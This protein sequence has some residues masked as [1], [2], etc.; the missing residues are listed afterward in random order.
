MDIRQIVRGSIEWE[1]LEAIARQLAHRADREVV[2]IE[3]MEADNWLSTPFVVDEEWFV[4]VI[5]PQNA[6]VH[7]VFTGARNLGAFS[8]GTEGF[9]ERFDGPLEMGQYEL[10]ATERMREIGLNAPEPVEVFEYDG[11]G[12]LVLEYLPEFRTLDELDREAFEGCASELLDSLATMHAHGLA[13]GD[14]RAENVLVADGELYFIDATSVSEGGRTDA[15]AYDLACALAVLEPRLGPKRAAALA[16]DS[17]DVETLLDAREFVDLINLRP[18]HEFDP[19]ALKGEIES[20]A[21]SP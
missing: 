18:D 20:L 16:L 6:V 8:R 4:K 21:T 15:V 1:Q 17:Y 10:E 9:F 3:F 19:V 7:A 14:L 2:R 11:F 5:T 12:V 13:H